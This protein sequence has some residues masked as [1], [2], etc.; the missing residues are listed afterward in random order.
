LFLLS[1][2][3]LFWASAGSV[4]AGPVYVGAILAGVGLG[5]HSVSG[6]TDR[7]T[8]RGAAFVRGTEAG[9]GLGLILTAAAFLV[10]TGGT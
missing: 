10:L 6:R 7:R 4:S 9:I 2:N 1:L 3:A 5:F 8:K